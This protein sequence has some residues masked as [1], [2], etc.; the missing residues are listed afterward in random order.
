MGIYMLY[1]GVVNLDIRGARELV[2]MHHH[3]GE[4][5]VAKDDH[6]HWEKEPLGVGT[7]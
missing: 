3:L 4:D 6:D 5:A 2:R 1:N 7:S